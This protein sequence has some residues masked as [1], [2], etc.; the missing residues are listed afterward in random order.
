MVEVTDETFE[1]EF[2]HIQK[3]IFE[4]AFAAFDMEFSGLEVKPCY[5]SVQ[6]DTVLFPFCWLC[7]V[8]HALLEN[9]RIVGGFV[10]G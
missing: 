6:V 4:S 2:L 3:V 7:I 5:K 9:E 10:D 8:C 1:R